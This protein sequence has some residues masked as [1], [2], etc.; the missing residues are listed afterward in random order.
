MQR[1]ILYI[2]N[3]RAFRKNLC[4]IPYRRQECA[5]QLDVL[6]GFLRKLKL[7]EAERLNEVV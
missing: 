6:V 1:K 2:I 4:V 7:R 3:S 5:H